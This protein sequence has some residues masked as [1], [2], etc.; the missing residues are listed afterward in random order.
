MKNNLLTFGAVSLFLFHFSFICAQSGYLDPTFGTGGTVY[1]DNP[2]PGSGSS[3][4]IALTPGGKIVS[5]VI[6]KTAGPGSASIMQF[7]TN[8]V[9]DDSFGEEGIC[10][11]VFGNL[12]AVQ[13]D[14]R[15]LVD[16]SNSS[17]LKRI[18]ADGQLDP[19][20]SPYTFPSF[21]SFEPVDLLVQP[22]G[23]IL[24]AGNDQSK[25]S[26]F[27]L[28]RHLPNGDPD[29]SF[30]TQGAVVSSLPQPG[31]F[32]RDI[33]LQPDGK[34]LA[35]GEATSGLHPLIA[36]YNADGTLDSSYATNGVAKVSFAGLVGGG[37]SAA[38]TADG[39]LVVGGN[40]GASIALLRLDATGK[41]D[42]T[43]GKNG[44]AVTDLSST[45]NKESIH[46]L[47][48]RSDGKI[49]VC[50]TINKPFIHPFCVQFTPDGDPDDTFEAPAS[51]ANIEAYSIK[52][53]LQPDDKPIICIYTEH[54]FM[55]L[56]LTPT[57]APDASYGNAGMAHVAF[58][59]DANAFDLRILP[60]D[61]ILTLGSAY[62]GNKRF[63]EIL[64]AR[65]LSNG[66]PDSSFGTQGRV[67]DS[68]A[69]NN[70]YNYPQSMD[71]QAD[72]RILVVSGFYNRSISNSYFSLILNRYLPNGTRDSTFGTN[73]M[74]HFDEDYPQNTTAVHAQQDGNI[75]LMINRLHPPSGYF[76]PHVYRFLPSGI[77]DST[78]ATNG[79]LTIAHSTG[80]DRGYA[81]GLQP[82][83]KIIVTGNY[84][85]PSNAG[86]FDIFIHR[87]NP[88]GTPDVSFGA[89]GILL[90]NLPND[91]YVSS[92]RDLLVQPDSK[93]LLSGGVFDLN[94]Q[95]GDHLLFRITSN[96]EPDLDFDFDGIVITDINDA[97]YGH[98]TDLALQPDGKI[99]ACG[100]IEASTFISFESLLIRYNPDG[101]LDN[102]FGLDGYSYGYFNSDGLT[103]C[104]AAG[105]QSNG[106]IVTTGSAVRGYAYDLG[107]AGFASGIVDAPEAGHGNLTARI[108]PNPV[109]DLL[110]VEYTL[111]NRAICTLGIYDVNG[112]RLRSVFPG[113]VKPAGLYRESIPVGDL[114]P[115]VYVIRLEAG[116]Q[117]FTK[118]FVRE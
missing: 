112:K 29:T 59:A 108:F 25:G 58:D 84:P 40:A 110:Q 28:L 43:F 97:G 14:G 35:V 85:S 44:V 47:L 95:G 87:Y 71:V 60:D 96:G 81:L 37:R 41:P 18:S 7:N 26:S 33:L 38:L 106:R 54:Q 15:I 93:I 118:A 4:S 5:T 109:K 90:P 13:G 99:I 16:R 98:V 101:S 76:K 12:I 10:S 65:F 50:G 113:R 72:G 27:I 75:L 53:V 52:T 45:A 8:G 21:P 63:N 79:I 20:F 116:T 82:D 103:G 89:N 74:I 69:P 105:V 49:L 78:F 3:F 92:F 39:K 73:G 57:G 83:G 115:G 100:W 2:N 111:E 1:L 42:S 68:P 30:G 11:R 64:L 62:N 46:T 55:I 17:N 107:I 104:E 88:D 24:R 114:S 6:I 102:S 56:R 77:L 61:R 48:I 19:G 9:P 32:L 94:N 23:K 31:E 86:Y 36:R 51:L 66:Q 91:Y 67:F 70:Y 80:V 117:S 22:D 34:I